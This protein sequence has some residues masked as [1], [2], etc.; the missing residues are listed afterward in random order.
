MIAAMSALTRLGV[1]HRVT[2]LV[3]AAENLPSGSVYDGELA[4]GATGFGTRLLLSWL[5]G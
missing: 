2:G 1:S 4:K 5:G 3:A